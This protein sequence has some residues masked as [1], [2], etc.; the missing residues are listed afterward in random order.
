MRV[1]DLDGSKRLTNNGRRWEATVTVT[2][3]DGAGNPV[4][5]A[6]VKGTWSNGASGNSSCTTSAGGTCSVVK[7][8]LTLSKNSVRLRV[9]NVTKAGATYN[10]ALNGDPD[11]DSNGTAITVTRP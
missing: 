7:G 3:R 4:S 8:G 1:T 6:T 5:G 2:V 10:A 11:G 9:S